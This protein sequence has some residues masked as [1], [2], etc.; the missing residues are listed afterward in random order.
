MSNVNPE[1]ALTVLE[2]H[3]ERLAA[4]QAQLNELNIRVANPVE[5]LD[6]RSDT[7]TAMVRLDQ[8]HYRIKSLEDQERQIDEGLNARSVARRISRIDIDLAAVRGQVDDLDTAI[9]ECNSVLTQRRK[10]IEATELRGDKHHET[11]ADLDRRLDKHNERINYNN[12]TGEGLLDMINDLDRR[13]NTENAART[14][15]DAN[16]RRMIEA[17][18]S[19]RVSRGLGHIGMIDAE[20]HRREHSDKDLGGRID[21]LLELVADLYTRVAAV[22]GGGELIDVLP[23]EEPS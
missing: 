8:Q 4:I 21:A 18:V 20:A 2:R 19:E 11:L 5:D 12:E 16:L 1:G 9:G 13:I 23:E 3:E 22:D 17:E 7:R 10:R 15:T 6:A 14:T